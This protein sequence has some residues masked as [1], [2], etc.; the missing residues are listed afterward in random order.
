MRHCPEAVMNSADDPVR[1]AQ[2]WQAV[3]IFSP[4]SLPKID[5]TN[6][7]VDLQGNDRA[8]WEQHSHLGDVKPGHAWRH[9]VYGGLYELSRVRDVLVAMYGQDREEDPR[10]YDPSAEAVTLDVT[11]APA[12]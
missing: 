3:E 9:E 10:D 11:V 6:H 2:F 1:I 4:Q 8:P 12:A 5:Q 7:V